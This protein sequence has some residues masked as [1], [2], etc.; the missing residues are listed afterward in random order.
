M[1]VKSAYD[2][3]VKDVL[4]Q[5]HIIHRAFGSN[6]LL[7]V[8]PQWGASVWMHPEM[9]KDAEDINVSIPQKLQEIFVSG[10]GQTMIE[11]VVSKRR[12]DLLK[13]KKG[14]KR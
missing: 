12:W 13:Y 6:S 11:S 10:Y 1:V 14:E 5:C 2:N 9:I 7:C 8:F 4:I 3:T